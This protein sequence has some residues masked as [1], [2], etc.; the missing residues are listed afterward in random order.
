MH[1]LDSSMGEFTSF[2][3]SEECREALSKVGKDSRFHYRSK[4]D[5]LTDEEYD[6]LLEAG[7]EG[8]V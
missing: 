4:Y 8:R 5:P 3:R 2:F 6:I 7:R 1:I